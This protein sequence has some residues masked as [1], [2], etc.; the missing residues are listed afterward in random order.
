[1]N[2]R[3][4]ALL[5]IASVVAGCATDE[6]K[7]A[8]KAAKEG[9]AAQV[10]EGGFSDDIAFLRAHTE[11]VILKDR[12]GKGQ[13]VVL[14]KMQGRIMTS[15]ATGPDGLSFGWVNRELIASGEFVKHINV[16]GGEDRF[17][18]GPEGGQ[19]SIF[20]EK[21]VPFDLEHWY[22]PAPFDTEPWTLVSKSA[23]AATLRKD[24]AGEEL[25]RRGV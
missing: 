4:V 21:G 6:S 25:L 12:S 10:Q 19:F 9:A 16:F 5:S 11:V 14:P 18:L 20:F 7:S 22:T 3:I 8:S 23:H 2:L 15:S 24:H 13:V 1:M 17:W